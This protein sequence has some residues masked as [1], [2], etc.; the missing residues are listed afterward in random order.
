MLSGV[1]YH[2]LRQGGILGR[3]DFVCVMRYPSIGSWQE[4]A[5][6]GGFQP[7]FGWMADM[8]LIRILS[9][10]LLGKVAIEWPVVFD[11]ISHCPMRKLVRTML[12]L[13]S[14]EWLR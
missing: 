7:V 12:K 1:D 2:Q 14:P 13:R 9:E 4:G 11:A 10:Q 5:A 8:A 3:L 6:S